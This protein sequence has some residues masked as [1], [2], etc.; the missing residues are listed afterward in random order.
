MK[1]NLKI[2]LALILLLIMLVIRNLINIQV[3]LEHK[4]FM[5]K[6]GDDFLL[7]VDNLKKEGIIKD[8]NIFIT[9]AYLNGDYTKIKP[10]EYIFDGKY[11]LKQIISILKNNL[12]ISVTIPEGFNIFQIENELIE[13]GIIKNKFELVNYK[14]SNL[15]EKFDKYPFLKYVDSDNNLEGFLYPNTYY[16]LKNTSIDEII[17]VFLDNFDKEIYIKI[18]NEVGEKDIYTKLILASL[19]EKEIYHKEDMPNALSVIKNR[20]NNNMLLQIDATLCYI[21]M[22]NNYINDNNI[23]CGVLTNVDKK[24]NSL[25]NTYMNKNMIPTPICSVNF[26][27]FEKVLKNVETKYFYYITDP[28]TK[29]T[30]FSKTLEEHNKNVSKYL[31]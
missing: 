5:I 22:S 9:F 25:Y 26:E 2:I 11:N 12:G 21:K 17:G 20:I 27:T 23:E 3:P 7:I 6:P 4:E 31:K 15:K 19:L 1:K 29:D 10:G 28:K 18:K 13:K 14:I 24:L 16:F 8:K 30:I